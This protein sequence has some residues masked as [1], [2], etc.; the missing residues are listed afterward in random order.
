MSNGLTIL[1]GFIISAVFM[2]TVW[3][4]SKN[5]REKN[6]HLSGI[7]KQKT[8]I[9]DI[10]ERAVGESQ[11]GAKPQQ[12]TSVN[13]G[14]PVWGKWFMALSV[15]PLVGSFILA[16]ME[17]QS[18]KQVTTQT[19]TPA[20]TI[21]IAVTNPTTVIAPIATAA[22]TMTTA[23]ASTTT[24][25]APIPVSTIAI[26]T[27]VTAS[28][29]STGNWWDSLGTPQYGGTLVVNDTTNPSFWDP[30]QGTLSSSLEFIYMDSL[31]EANWITNP[32]AQNYQLSYWDESYETGDLLTGWEFTAPGVLVLHVRQGVYWQNIA[33]A[34]G[35]QFNANDIVFHFNRM[36]GLGSGYTAPADPVYYSSNSWDTTLVSVKAN[37]NWTVTMTFNT[38]NPEFILENMQ[39]PGCDC[40]IE[41]PETV[42][43]Y[44]N[45]AN[46]ELT[47]WHNA[48][49]TGPFMIT[50][51]VDMSSVTFAKNPNYW[52][53]DERYQQ[54]K[55]PYIDT[56]IVLIIPNTSTAEAAM[57]TGKIDLMDSISPADAI[58]MKK[59]NP[60]M[61]EI[62]CPNGNGLSLNPRNDL[63]PYNDIRVREALQ[64]AINLPQIASQYFGGGCDP[65]P[66]ALTS[67]FMAA[68]GFPYSSWPADLQAQY[69]YNP[70]GAKALLAAAGFPNGFNTDVV[71]DST[72]PYQDL[73]QVLQSE[74]AAV[75]VNMSIQIM[76]HA[77]FSAYVRTGHHEDALAY[78]PNG[79]LG[80]GYYPIRQLM[81]FVTGGLSNDMMVADPKIDGW[82]S[83]ALAATTVPQVKQIVHDENQYVVQQH[84][85]ISLVQPNVYFL[86]QPWVVG[87]NAQYG[88]FCDGSGSLM[89]FE[90]YARFSINP[91]AR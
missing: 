69:A 9:L 60:S 75:G 49:G 70:T 63:A 25:T 30:N 21:A 83:A 45:A 50:S 87:F 78:L 65:S 89:G 19:T 85:L 33:P 74:F 12:Q 84:F 58:N 43:A 61:N 39:A 38:P 52:A 8:E 4:A 10:I 42:Q 40:S 55:L 82:Y 6:R 28:T 20:T 7:E 54:N 81:K 34:G 14:M 53:S 64:M 91:S 16:G 17:G 80:L 86:S 31:F 71:V 11:K 88:A 68:W 48:L 24:S 46:P 27:T 47:N 1:I 57:H 44:T 62:E 90:Y 35:R 41:S 18:A 13:G 56:L 66:E 26:A 77:Q 29:T 5:T 67:N 73:M 79:S 72:A 3:L 23:T 76:A 15:V 36:C 22:T 32:S 37:D 2:L 59:T 51:F